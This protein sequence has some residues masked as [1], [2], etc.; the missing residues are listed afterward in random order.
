MVNQT[1]ASYQ[2]A[3]AKGNLTS[4]TPVSG[5]IRNDRNLLLVLQ[6]IDDGNALK[7]SRSDF[8]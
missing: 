4:E 2:I 3:Y 8:A 6:L 5:K 7:Y 1:I